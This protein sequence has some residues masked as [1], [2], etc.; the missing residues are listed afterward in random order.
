MEVVPSFKTKKHLSDWLMATVTD[1]TISNSF[2][3]QYQGT[4]RV[5][6]PDALITSPVVYVS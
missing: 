4:W 1:L 2:V 5:I 6:A 3:E